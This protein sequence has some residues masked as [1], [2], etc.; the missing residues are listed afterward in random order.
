MSAIDRASCIELPTKLGE[1]K[2]KILLVVRPLDVPFHSSSDREFPIDIDAV[3]EPW[4]STNEEINYRLS[5]RPTAR[6]GE[7]RV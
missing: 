2:S 3:E 4:P 6:V 5:E 7:R 1:K